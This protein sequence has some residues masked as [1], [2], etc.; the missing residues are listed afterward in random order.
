MRRSRF[1][2]SSSS[3][4][5]IVRIMLITGIRHRDTETQRWARG[6]E[7]RRKD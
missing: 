6:E 7:E 3:S 5:I 2:A 1:R 4:T